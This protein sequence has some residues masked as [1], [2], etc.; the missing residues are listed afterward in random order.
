MPV[1]VAFSYAGKET[2][3]IAVLFFFLYFF[4]LAATHLLFLFYAE[5]R[6]SVVALNATKSI[7]KVGVAL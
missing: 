6:D 7:A 4:F 3:L 2:F 1:S 5:V